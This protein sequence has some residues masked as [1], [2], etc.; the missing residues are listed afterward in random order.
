MQSSM[1]TG[2]ASYISRSTN[3]GISPTRMPY[4]GHGTI[5]RAADTKRR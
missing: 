5:L 3:S 2:L 4:S 1:R